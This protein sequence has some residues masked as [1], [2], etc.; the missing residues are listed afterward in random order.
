MGRHGGAVCAGHKAGPWP[1]HEAF[2][3]KPAW[4][5]GTR[6]SV[7]TIRRLMT[8]RSNHRAVACAAALALHCLS[9]AVRAVDAV[10]LEVREVEIDGM[11]VQDARAQLD[12][13]D[14]KNTRVTLKAGAVT[15]PAP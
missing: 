1:R 10:V 2:V 15:L 5:C 13:L 9:P 14:E 4:T 11:V 8:G 6:D 3:A 12:L 7:A